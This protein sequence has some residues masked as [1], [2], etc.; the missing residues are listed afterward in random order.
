MAEGMR[1]FLVGF[2][3]TADRSLVLAAN[4]VLAAEEAAR[5]AMENGRTPRYLLV[6]EVDPSDT[7]GLKRAVSTAGDMRYRVRESDG[8]VFYSEHSYA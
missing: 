2:N 8:A 7:P 5:V 1:R 6:Y 4:P 3:G